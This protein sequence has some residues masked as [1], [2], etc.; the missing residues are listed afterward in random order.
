MYGNLN[1]GLM[2][3][4]LRA[5][6]TGNVLENAK[7]TVPWIQTD[8]TFGGNLPIF[9]KDG[10]SVWTASA[11][12]DSSGVAF[13]QFLWDPIHIGHFI[14]ES[15][16]AIVRGRNADQGETYEIKERGTFA[17]TKVSRSFVATGIFKRFHLCVNL[18]QVLSSGKGEFQFKSGSGSAIDALKLIQRILE[19]RAKIKGE[20]I[21]KLQILK[22]MRPSV[23]MYSLVGAV[24]LNLTPV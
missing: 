15:P 3:C 19:F 6:D 18:G 1:P 11:V 14:D 10:R 2:I 22:V 20:K 8:Q 21:P 5:G 24:E 12:S 9:D 23:E 13:V 16:M 17:D 4:F 7:A